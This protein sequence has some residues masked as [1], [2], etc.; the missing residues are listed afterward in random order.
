MASTRVPWRFV[1][2]PDTYL[3][4]TTVQQT[5]AQ[6]PMF[7]AFESDFS[8][9]ALNIWLLSVSDDF[10]AEKLNWLNDYLLD[11]AKSAH[12]VVFVD[13]EQASL[14][15]QMFWSN[16]LKQNC[17]SLPVYRLSQ[18]QLP[19]SALER[20]EQQISSPEL[21]LK[22]VHLPDLQA[23]DFAVNTLCLDHLLMGLS[24]LVEL[25]NQQIFHVSGV[26]E[27]LEYSHLVALNLSPVGWRMSAETSAK[28]QYKI[29]VLGRD[30]DEGW[31]Q[32]IIDSAQF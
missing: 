29:S 23:L 13:S 5:F 32:E 3:W 2:L 19:Q 17:V 15:K 10:D 22:S 1:S 26:V 9:P 20:L 12:F 14:D 28:S 27:T 21:S 4:H 24:N 25:K 8:V 7:D 6:W 31:L 16:W 11:I 30:L 18:N